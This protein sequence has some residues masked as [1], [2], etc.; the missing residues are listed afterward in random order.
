M[1]ID[2]K[3]IIITQS[4]VKIV[5]EEKNTIKKINYYDLMKIYLENFKI[6]FDLRLIFERQFGAKRNIED[7]VIEFKLSEDFEALLDLYIELIEKN[8]QFGDIPFSKHF[9]VKKKD[10]M[11]EVNLKKFTCLKEKVEYTIEIYKEHLKMI[12]DRIF[13]HQEIKRLEKKL[14]IFKPERLFKD[15]FLKKTI[16]RFLSY[17]QIETF[18]DAFISP[19]KNILYYEDLIPYLYFRERLCGCKT[20]K[21]INNVIIDNFQNY[22]L[23]QLKLLCKMFPESKII[24]TGN[25]RQSINPY[26]NCLTEDVLNSIKCRY[27]EIKKDKEKNVIERTVRN[28]MELVHEIQRRAKMAYSKFKDKVPILI[29]FKSRKDYFRFR[30]LYKQLRRLKGYTNRNIYYIYKDKMARG[31]INIMMLF[32]IIGMDFNNYFMHTFVYKANTWNFER[33]EY[34]LDIIR[35][36]TKDKIYLYSLGGTYEL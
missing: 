14:N 15:L 27:V 23:N 6:S 10:V 35:M 31:G 22:N 4:K 3:N 19:I 9:S 24:I 5:N 21:N 18:R 7:K 34:L 8:L 36:K 30:I 12:P 11:K 29:L 13:Q 17:E 1:S 25:R 20:Y 33:N 16:Y 32:D 2:A 28:D 26:R